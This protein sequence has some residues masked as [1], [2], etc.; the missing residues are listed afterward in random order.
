VKNQINA[1]ALASTKQLL[2]DYYSDFEKKISDVGKR[3][4]SNR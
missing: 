3:E 2:L 4:M 1:P